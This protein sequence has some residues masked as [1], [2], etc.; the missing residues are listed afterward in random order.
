MNIKGKLWDI[1]KDAYQVWPAKFLA[2][3]QTEVKSQ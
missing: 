3:Q 2:K 1:N